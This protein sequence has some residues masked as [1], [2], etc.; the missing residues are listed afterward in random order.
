[1]TQEPARRQVQIAAAV[2]FYGL[3]LGE[4]ARGLV[5]DRRACGLA[6]LV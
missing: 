6:E 2:F 1:M 5:G 4:W 3:E